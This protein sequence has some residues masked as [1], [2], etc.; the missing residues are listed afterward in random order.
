MLCWTANAHADWAVIGG[1]ELNAPAGWLAR[2]GSVTKISKLNAKSYIELFRVEQMPAAETQAF[3][4]WLREL[5]MPHPAD[6]EITKAAELEQR[7]VKAVMAEGTAKSDDGKA[8]RLRIIVLP[9]ENGAVVVRASIREDDAEK[10]KQEFEE[11][12]KT[13]GVPNSQPGVPVQRAPE[14]APEMRARSMVA[15]LEEE[16]VRLRKDGKQG[17]A[18][19][20][21]AKVTQWQDELAGRE[22]A[23][24]PEPELHLVGVNEG[25]L[26]DGP[27]K[28]GTVKVQV[29]IKDSPVVLA[30][31][32][33]G[34]VRWELTVGEGVRVQRIILMGNEEQ[35]I[36]GA[37]EGAVVERHYRT[38]GSPTNA[39]AYKEGELYRQT[40][41]VLHTLTG[42][43][44]ST[45]MGSDRAPTAP[46]VLGPINKDW[47]IGRVLSEAQGEY[48]QATALDR[49]QRRE[50]IKPL[51]YAALMWQ[52]Q[53]RV[54]R[55]REMMTSTASLARFEGA[56]VL[57]GTVRQLPGNMQALAVDPT[58]PA[59]YAISGEQVMRVNLDT[60]T[61]MPIAGDLSK[62]SSVRGISFDIKR[63]RL[64]VATRGGQLYSYEPDKNLLSLV[65]EMNNVVVSS[66][67]YSNEEDCLYGLSTAPTED[68]DTVTHRFSADGVLQE[69][70]VVPKR[71]SLDRI[72][73]MTQV[74]SLGAN[75][76]VLW[77][78]GEEMRVMVIE[79][80]TNTILYEGPVK[81][82][83]E[84]IDAEL[85][86]M[87]EQLG[88]AP[89]DD[90]M[91]L[92]RR[93]AS[94]GHRVVELIQKLPPAQVM[95]EQT[96]RG[97]IAKLDHEDFREREAATRALLRAGDGAVK[98][99]KDAL[100]A[101]P[102]PEMRARVEALLM[103]LVKTDLSKVE[104]P[105][106]RREIRAMRVLGEM[107]SVEAVRALR[108]FAAEDRMSSRARA[109]REALSAM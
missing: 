100:A 106:L 26:P 29:E 20:L 24:R 96:L 76:A 98:P 52:M 36:V 99:L 11:V 33:H 63:R 91:E 23:P 17:A 78:N 4:K 5:K 101:S 10:L 9:K 61:V 51:K 66:L 54:V 82:R 75:L 6:M 90:A 70:K 7:G 60:Q 56:D 94:G 48:L 39:Y 34:A 12:L 86:R 72:G 93:M 59:Y 42:L 15:A 2:P 45:F 32:A 40:Q 107:G 95:D 105:E 74:V 79:W 18:T 3:S 62:L 83:E 97:L 37:P 104:S 13:V 88:T 109:A 41:A 14:L 108:E 57:K 46:I 103:E 71:S 92:V 84:I 77:V 53:R 25:L 49:A 19:E 16:V 87:W 1:V 65:H 47:R 31:C 44:V 67:N 50:N 69:K 64:L 68:D 102:S 80:K 85:Q 28:F 27:K 30:M 21:S 89:E 43:P 8:L 22:L 58:G 73:P 81:M 35:D 55:Q 38:T